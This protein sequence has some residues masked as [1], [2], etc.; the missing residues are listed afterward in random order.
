MKYV[1]RLVHCTKQKFAFFKSYRLLIPFKKKSQPTKE[2]NTKCNRINR[3]LQYKKKNFSE[4]C[5]KIV[6]L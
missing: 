6:D 5:K 1:K 4:R 2:K 3:M